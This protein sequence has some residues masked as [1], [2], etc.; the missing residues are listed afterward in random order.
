MSSL[1]LEKP[2]S[3]SVLL[4]VERQSRPCHD[5]TKIPSVG[6]LPGLFASLQWMSF[7]ATPTTAAPEQQP[8]SANEKALIVRRK[9]SGTCTTGAVTTLASLTMSNVAYSPDG[10]TIAVSD[11]WARLVRLIDRATGVVTT[12]AGSGTAPYAT[13]IL[14]GETASYAAFADGIGSAASFNGPT[15][16]AYSSDGST[17]AV[18]DTGNYRVRLI[19]VATGAVTTLAGSG[20]MAAEAAR[21]GS[22]VVGGVFADGIGTAASFYG[23]QGV[24]YSPDDSTIAVADSG[25]KRVRLIDVATGAVTTLAGS[26]TATFADGIGS[27]ASFST[28]KDVVYSPDGS[29]IAVADSSANRVRLIDVATGAVTTLAGGFNLPSPSTY[30]FEERGDGIGSAASF[31]SP[32]GLD[33]SPDGSTIAVAGY[34]NNRVRL[35]DV[36]TGSVT[37]LAGASGSTGNGAGPGNGAFADGTGSAARFK[38]P[39][40]LAYSPDGSSIVVADTNNQRGS[41]SDELR[42]LVR[43]ICTGI[44]PAPTPSPT[45]TPTMS[46]TPSPTTSPTPS[47]T[48]APTMS[49]TPSPTTSPTSSPSTAPSTKF[50]GYTN[51]QDATG[52]AGNLYTGAKEG[53]A[54]AVTIAAVSLVFVVVLIAIVVVLILKVKKLTQ[55]QDQDQGPSTTEQSGVITNR[56]KKVVL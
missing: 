31:Y 51:S 7:G 55:H 34:M 2:F 6:A 32:Q 37:T 27:A 41:G 15:D 56:A 9:L 39:S 50:D 54:V 10:S 25:N 19:D 30:S 28:P 46:P 29:T 24:A 11:P 43:E 23:P 14:R 3:V 44:T 33:Y 4:I 35:S 16:L 5:L 36:A 20:S 42:G 45:A 8:L 1:R 49:P 48:A 47:P 22:T 38:S 53:D 13:W 52:S 26:G 40:S 21:G 17:I 12:L 18:A